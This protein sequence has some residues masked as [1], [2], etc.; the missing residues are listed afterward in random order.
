MAS[1][2]NRG[3]RWR[4]LVRMN[5]LSKCATFDTRALA[6]E[7]AEKVEGEI[8]QIK[9]R[10][11]ITAKGKTLG[12]LI[13]RYVEEL[14]PI[15]RWGRSKTK[16]LDRLKRDLGHIKASQLTAAHLTHYF[17]KR[18]AGG[19]GGVVVGAQLGYLRGVLQT[20]RSLWHLDVPVQAA[21]A[22]REALAGVGMTSKSKRRDRRV[23]DAEITKLIDHFNKQDTGVPMAE[24]IRFCVATAMRISE[25]CSLRWEDLDEQKRTVI[26]RDRKHPSD[27]WGND[28][29]VPLLDAT[30][31]D[32]FAIAVRQPRRGERIFPYNAKTIGTYVTRAVADLGLVDLHLHDLRHE[33]ITRL[34]AAGYRI[35]QVA[36]VSGHR[37]WAML[38]RYTHVRAED[39]HR[40]AA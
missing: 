18:R 21:D 2:I 8:E 13:D 15:K 22:A 28:M 30:G 5:G 34:F 7:W 11:V 1:I 26:V 29:T 38:K 14:E 35:E 31:Y 10:G 19:A 4:A 33:G 27:K 17:T 39:L 24:I 3:G 25:V 6:K 12:N 32:A 20:A 23:T 9:A 36:L 37:D 16:D 40:A